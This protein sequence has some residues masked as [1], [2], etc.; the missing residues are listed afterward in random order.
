[1]SASRVKSATIFAWHS[2]EAGGDER[3]EHRL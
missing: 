2:R 1:M 3:V